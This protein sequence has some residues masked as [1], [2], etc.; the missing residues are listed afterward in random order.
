MRP[1]HPQDWRTISAGNK[2]SLKFFTGSFT[3]YGVPIGRDDFVEET[4]GITE[5]NV[6]SSQ[7]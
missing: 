3:L 5:F 6:Q 4:R 2:S 7:K 1:P